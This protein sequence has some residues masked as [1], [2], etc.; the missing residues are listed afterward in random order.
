MQIEIDSSHAE[1]N[2]IFDFL[3]FQAT[4]IYLREKAR[5]FFYEYFDFLSDYKHLKVDQTPPVLPLKS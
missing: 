5:Y 1:K 3:T 4:R 2:L